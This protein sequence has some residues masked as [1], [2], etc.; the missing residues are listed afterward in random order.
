MYCKSAQ[1]SPPPPLHIRL[2]PAFVPS[3]YRHSSRRRCNTSG[4]STSR[5]P[6]VRNASVKRTRSSVSFAQPGDQGGLVLGAEQAEAAVLA[7]LGALVPLCALTPLPLGVR[8]RWHAGLSG[9]VGD[10]A[11][12]NVLAAI[13]E[14]SIELE[15]FEQ[16][17][18][19][20]PG[21]A[22]LVA[23]KFTLVRG[24]GP[25]LGEFFRVPVLLHARRSSTLRS[26]GEF[27][28]KLRLPLH[29]FLLPR[30][31]APLRDRFSPIRR[32][33]YHS[34]TPRPKPEW[35]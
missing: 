4:L 2:R 13:R 33:S 12:G 15:S 19:A 10:D 22:R 14:A 25:V 7:N 26:L 21:G 1:L 29:G 27:R 20:E 18:E 11:A 34:S 16:D 31:R 32:Q 17:G 28:L 23:E 30:I 6:I 9:E 35:L 8:F 24:E 5:V 3:P